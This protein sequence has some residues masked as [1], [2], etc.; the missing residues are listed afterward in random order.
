MAH[1]MASKPRPRHH[2]ELLG[3]LLQSD[4]PVSFYDAL[5]VVRQLRT[6][7]VDPPDDLLQAL[8]NFRYERLRLTVNGHAEGD[9]VVAISLLGANPE[10][11]DGQPYEFNLNVDGRLVDLVRQSGAVYRIPAQ[12]EAQLGEIAAEAR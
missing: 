11:R 8:R 3:E 2:V 1:T 4:T 9:V 10:H 7:T 12:I 6:A 5:M